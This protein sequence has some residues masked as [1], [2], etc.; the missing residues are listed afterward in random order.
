[1]STKDR[2]SVADALHMLVVQLI[3]HEHKWTA[4]ERKACEKALRV[5]GS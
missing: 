5:L 2:D 3:K 1:M 4:K